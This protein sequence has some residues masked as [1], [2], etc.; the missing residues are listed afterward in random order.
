MTEFF[1]SPWMLWGAALGAA[2]V[3]IHLLNKR[4]YRE[5][6]WAAMR[7]LIQA[8]RKQSRR[9]R[10]EQLILLALRV[11]LLCLLA[12]A[13]AEP[14]FAELGIISQ[15]DAPTHKILVL[16]A[17][18]SMG[19]TQENR[20]RFQQAQQVAREIV[21]QSGQGDVFNLVRIA[22]APPHVIITTPSFRHGEV[23]D[24][25]SLLELPHGRGE[26]TN[27]LEKIENLL[28]PQRG[29]PRQKH[30]YF[31][32]DFQRAGWLPEAESRLSQLR[33]RLKEISKRANLVCIDLGKSGSENSAITGFHPT[34]LHIIANRTTQFEATVQNFGRIPQT[35]RT[36][37]FL[38][39][40]K[41]RASR[42]VDL[43]PG[44][45][46]SEVFSHTFSGGGEHRV[47]VR[48][49][50]D[51]LSIDDERWLSVPVKA[52]FNVLC[53]AGSPSAGSQGNATDYLALALQVGEASASS[54][55]SFQTRVIGSGDLQGLDLQGF[56]C[57]FLCNVALIT[58]AEARILES[59]LK[60]GGGVV[61][62]LGDQ[63]DVENYNAQ[64]FREGKGILPA[65]IGP[66]QGNAV[67]RSEAFSFDP[68]DYAHPIISAFQGNP[69]AGLN[70]TLTYEYF[71]LTPP[72]RGGQTTV[73]RFDTG[74]P[75]I[76]EGT[77]GGT[78]GV[79]GGRSIV[80]A[81]T[82]DDSWSNWALWPSFLPMIHEIAFSASKG[83][84]GQREFLVNQPLHRIFPTGVFDVPVSVVR[85]GG[86]AVETRLSQ[87]AESSEFT[88]ADTQISGI[89][90]VK[91]GAPLSR[92]ELFAVNVETI[93]SDLT[94]LGRDEL[95]AE[96]LPGIEFDYQTDWESVQTTAET[97]LT[98]HGELS[99]GLLYLVLYLLFTEQ[100]MAWRFHYGLW[101]L[102]P[103]LLVIEAGRRVLRR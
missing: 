83:R 37:E 59:Y 45:A 71:Q 79:G 54:L 47:H 58:P 6:E 24:E 93:E 3:I 72:P 77:V 86:S 100:L 51:S 39:D 80:I 96:L 57:V 50:A 43:L 62:C 18:F 75:A 63:V 25:I 41:L 28:E 17:T 21:E 101:M 84:Q 9:I 90:E 40:G 34:D 16:D 48:L 49:Q 8:V 66:R 5:T 35:G 61:W 11:L 81:T 69:R 15:A 7:F 94:S 19:F 56:D 65:K 32:S 74:D 60:S 95:S 97:T 4:K 102:C 99:R 27:T 23:L 76:I 91:F 52:Q 78:D 13:L 89:Y 67:Q 92:D 68:G 44:T 85:P 26:I 2:P 55:S 31:I 82:V 10:L 103:P 38:V 70:S 29:I 87:S 88:Y 20:S 12:V 36:L 33:N 30:V 1:T 42:S 64:L 46:V 22:E 73:L 14:Q 53:V 98:A